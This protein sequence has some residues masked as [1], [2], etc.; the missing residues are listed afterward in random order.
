MAPGH[1]DEYNQGHDLFRHDFGDGSLMPRFFKFRPKGAPANFFC[2]V[3]DGVDPAEHG[4]PKDAIEVDRL[5]GEFEDHVKG[6]GWVKDHDAHAEELENCR[7]R[8]MSPAKRHREHIET[9]KREL[10]AELAKEKGR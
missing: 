6:A 8:A 5:P 9:A 1:L 10:R 7:L 4:I 2:E 3:A